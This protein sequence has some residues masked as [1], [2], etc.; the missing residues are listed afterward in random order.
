MFDTEQNDGF[1]HPQKQSTTS[2]NFLT[3]YYIINLICHNLL[4]T[5][6]KLNRHKTFRRLP[7][8]PFKRLCTFH[9][10]PVSR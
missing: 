1:E 9:L 6:R 7:V 2:R 8:T 5:G 3:L 10:P 4:N